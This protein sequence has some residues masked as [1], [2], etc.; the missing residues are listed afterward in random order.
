[1]NHYYEFSIKFYFNWPSNYCENI[2]MYAGGR[3]ISATLDEMSKVI[4]DLWYLPIVIVSIWC[5]FEQNTLS[6]A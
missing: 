2:F 3:P 6:T 5:V 4:I 1:M